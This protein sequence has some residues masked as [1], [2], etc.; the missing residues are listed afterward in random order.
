MRFH[1][2]VIFCKVY[3]LNLRHKSAGF[4][5]LTP[6]LVSEAPLPAS[7]RSEGFPPSSPCFSPADPLPGQL[8]LPPEHPALPWALTAAT[9]R[10]GASWGQ[11]PPSAV[12]NC[13]P[14]S[15]QQSP[16]DAINTRCAC[17]LSHSA[18]SNSFAT[19][20][21]VAH[22]ATVHGV[23][24]AGILEWV[25]ISS[26]RGSSQ[27]RDRTHVSWVSCNSRWILYHWE[28]QVNR[29]G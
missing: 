18:V 21:T 1:W 12:S 6:F 9:E 29:D 17:L 15:T 8:S 23:S 22:Q 14:H 4:G 27:P 28:A 19:L 5:I 2:F 3:D 16:T 7:L 26:S 25:A 11:G 10:L 13:P 24:Q 20:W